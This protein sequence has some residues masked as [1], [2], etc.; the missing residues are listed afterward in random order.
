MEENKNI[1]NNLLIKQINESDALGFNKDYFSRSHDVNFD[2]L[3]NAYRNMG[4]VY[5]KIKIAIENNTCESP[6]CEYEVDQLKKLESAPDKSIEFLSTLLSQLQIT[7]D[8]NFDPN[9]NFE[10][11]A[12]NCIFS[13]KPGFSKTDGYNVYLNILLDGSQEIIFTGPLFE[14]P[15][16]IN[17]SALD[18][19]SEAGTTLVSDTPDI[20]KEMLTLLTKIGLFGPEAILE[21]GELAPTAVITDEFVLRNMDG[22]YDYEIIDIGG[23]KGRNILKFDIDKIERKVDPFINA[24]VAGLLSQEQETVAAWNVYISKGTSV[25]EDAQMVQNANAAK[26][27]W[28]YEKDLPLTQDKKVLFENKYKEYFLNNY[29]KP[30]LTN[31]FP[32][33]EKDAAVFDLA[34]AKKA[35]AQKFIDDNQL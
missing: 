34:E 6:N 31:K 2:I 21:T 7:E 16:I 17:S 14:K 19:L 1:Y 32:T 3:G 35:K 9:N 8:P 13:E 10:F 4:K 25:Q 30:F 5:A 20:N 26:S 22:T 33:V 23:G 27:S 29:L 18:A 12:A 15:L 28:S 24:E 11:T